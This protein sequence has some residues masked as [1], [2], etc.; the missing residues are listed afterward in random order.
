MTLHVILNHTQVFRCFDLDGS[1][2]LEREEFRLLAKMLSVEDQLVSPPA[3]YPL[4]ES[5]FGTSM[6]QNLGENQEKLFLMTHIVF[7]M[8][9][10]EFERLEGEVVKKEE[11]VVRHWS[12]LLFHLSLVCDLDFSCRMTRIRV[13]L[14]VRSQP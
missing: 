11:E 3:L 13:P 8:Q 4:T 10:E 9:M 6:N 2:F 1:G 14:T 5:I 12:T 7:Y